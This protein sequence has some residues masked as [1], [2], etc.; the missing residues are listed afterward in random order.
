MKNFFV[1][2]LK[3]SNAIFDY[4]FALVYHGGGGFTWRDTEY[5]TPL[6]LSALVDKLEK[7]KQFEREQ[8]LE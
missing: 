2:T 8:S 4:Q 7:Q 6:E 3:E 5:L 1:P